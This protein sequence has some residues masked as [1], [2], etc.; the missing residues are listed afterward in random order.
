MNELILKAQ[1]EEITQYHIYKFLSEHT[2]NPQ[3]KKIL[4]QISNE[5]LSHYNYWKTLTKQELPHYPFKLFRYKLLSK[6]FGS[7]FTLRSLE[8]EEKSMLVK[9]SSITKQYPSSKKIIYASEKHEDK[10]IHLINEE[11]LNYLGA[12]VLGINDALVELT[13]ALAGFTFALKNPNLIAITG[14][15]TGIAASLSM[16]ASEYL[17]AKSEN[18][19]KART[20]AVY[21]GIAY[22]ITVLFLILPY[23]IIENIYFALFLMLF[24]A[25]LV[26]LI[27]TYYLS[28]AKNFSFKQKFLEMAVISIGVAFISFIFGF[29]INHF[30]GIPV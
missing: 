29:I 1:R 16:A 19:K 25:I 6:I 13:G 30:F 9:F 27:F 5:E 26:I 17:S 4:T 2:N 3:E 22:V 15:I 11:R 24:N 7:T 21:T 14:L 12:I 20:A 18:N 23:F 10:L 8:N 28:V